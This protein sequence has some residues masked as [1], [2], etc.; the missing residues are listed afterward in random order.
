MFNCHPLLQISHGLCEH[1]LVCPENHL[2]L[3]IGEE[4]AIV[5]LFDDLEGAGRAL[6]MVIIHSIFYCF[7]YHLYYYRCGWGYFKWK[8]SYFCFFDL[9]RYIFVAFEFFEWRKASILWNKKLTPMLAMF[10][11]R[12]ARILKTLLRLLL[13]TRPMRRKDLCSY[14]SWVNFNL[15]II[16]RP[17]QRMKMRIQTDCSHLWMR[18]IMR[19]R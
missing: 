8:G 16:N 9:I 1:D 15:F 7:S 2:L 11:L 5:G 4:E 17:R 3:S 10:Q 18:K 14:F 12:K 19:G 13:V 6:L